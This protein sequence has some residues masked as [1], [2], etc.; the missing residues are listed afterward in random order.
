[1]LHDILSRHG[2]NLHR[3]WPPILFILQR[4]AAVQNP[5]TIGHTQTEP[6]SPRAQQ[7]V[8]ESGSDQPEIASEKMRTTIL[9][10]R[11]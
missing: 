2:Q 7:K 5:P 11:F 1:V 3:G 6:K 4:A 8:P 9:Q 10:V